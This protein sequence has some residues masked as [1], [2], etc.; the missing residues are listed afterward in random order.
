MLAVVLARLS[1]VLVTQVKS[2]I[3]LSLTAVLNRPIRSSLFQF[4]DCRCANVFAHTVLFCSFTLITEWY[5]SRVN[6]SEK[7]CFSLIY[8]T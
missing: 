5:G 4:I 8:T 3:S 2:I 6:K 1:W 7:N